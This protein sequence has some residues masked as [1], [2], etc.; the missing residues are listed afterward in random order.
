M[1][2]STE[3][4]LG[5]SSLRLVYIYSLRRAFLAPTYV[6]LDRHSQGCIR[7]VY[8]LAIQLQIYVYLPPTTATT[9]RA[10]ST[11]SIY[12]I[13]AFSNLTQLGLGLGIGPILLLV[14]ASSKYIQSIYLLQWY[15]KALGLVAPATYRLS[16]SAIKRLIVSVGRAYT[17]AKLRY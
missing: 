14:Y 7:L 5:R 3:A 17:K 8:A 1:A 16:K 2:D 10:L 11:I 13:Y 6:V 9:A 12:F 15:L 4:G